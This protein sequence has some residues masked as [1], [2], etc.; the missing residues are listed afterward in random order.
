MHIEPNELFINFDYAEI[1]FAL[2][3]EL[4]KKIGNNYGI[5]LSWFTCY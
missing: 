2:T 1:E 3:S 5:R 4:E